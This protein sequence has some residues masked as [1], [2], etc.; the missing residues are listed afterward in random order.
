MLAINRI[1]NK[2]TELIKQKMLKSSK[3]RQLYVNKSKD[4]EF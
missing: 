2:S 3:W 4:G 1:S